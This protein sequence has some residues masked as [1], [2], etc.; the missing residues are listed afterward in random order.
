MNSSGYNLENLHD[1][2]TIVEGNLT[3]SGDVKA[4]DLVFDEAKL[5]G[6]LDCDGNN[7]INCGNLQA[8]TFN[9]GVPITNPLSSN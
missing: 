7:I 8:T 4:D 9:G 6:D 1:G 5:G 2:N 3:V